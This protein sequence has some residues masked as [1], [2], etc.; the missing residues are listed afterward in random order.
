MGATSPTAAVVPLEPF[1]RWV[2]RGREEIVARVAQTILHEVPDLTVDGGDDAAQRLRAS[3]DSHMPMFIT[4]GNGTPV[5][6]PFRLPDPAD[7]YATFLARQ[8]LPLLT[9]L[10][11]Y[12][13]GH[14]EFWRLFA[15]ALRVGPDRLEATGRADALE[16][17]S[18]LM[19]DYI[20][21]VTALAVSA[22]TRTCTYMERRAS[23]QRIEVVRSI[24]SGSCDDLAAERF[25][26]YRLGPEHVGYVGWLTGSPDL[27][28]LEDVITELRQHLEPL[29]HVAIA[30][31]DFTIHG[32]F[33]VRGDGWR[34][35]LRHLSLPEGTA[36]ACGAP[37]PGADGFRAT[38]R[39]ALETR[40]VAEMLGMERPAVYEDM[41]VAVIAS[42]DPDHARWLVERELGC[43][44]STDAAMCR[45]VST[46]ETYLMELGSPTRAGRRLAL[47][48]N[49]V[50]QRLRRIEELRGRP[51]DATS[52]SLRVAVALAPLVR[53]G[54]P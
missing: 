4:L 9:L 3:I 32:W 20:Q 26:E 41:A 11:A 18:T 51:V 24:L 39:E 25:L 54:S 31:G 14:A 10:R 52:L 16:R 35:E 45:L 34:D 21:A 30:D 37:H 13:V 48:P 50:I 46:L 17:T 8:G 6:K 47:H 23:S 53:A 2:E 33:T 27:V 49:T 38:H 22:H 15:E 5:R 44:A 40:R 7:R 42:R 29:Q 43:L 1:V 36:I 12:E 19:F 28:Q